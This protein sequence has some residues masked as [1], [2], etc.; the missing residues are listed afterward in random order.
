MSNNGGIVFTQNSVVE[1]MLDIVGYNPNLHLIK[2][3]LLEPACGE[4]AFLLPVVRRLLASM[5]DGADYATL[6]DAIRAYDIEPKHVLR[7][8]EL[9]KTALISSKVSTKDADALI[10]TWIRRGDFL[11]Q[12]NDQKY[13]FIVGNPPYVGMDKLNRTL[14]LRYR[15]LYSTLHDRTDIYVAFIEKSLDI[16]SRAG[17]L[18]FICT[19]RW[20]L[21][22]YGGLLR[23]KITD[24]FKLLNYIDLK[25]T[26]PFESKVSTYPSIFTIAHGRTTRVVTALLDDTSSKSCHS[27]SRALR[28]KAPHKLV[29]K[30][31]ILTTHKKWFQGSNPWLIN[32]PQHIQFLYE[33]EKKYEPIE[34][35]CRVGIGIA[36][37]CDNVYIIGKSMTP[38]IEATRTVPLVMRMDLKD[39]RIQSK[40]NYIINTFEADGTVVNLESYPLLKRY[41]DLHKVAVEKRHVAKKN[42]KHWHRTIDRLHLDLIKKPKL[43]I[44]DIAGCNQV[45]FDPGNFYPHH[46]I[47]HITSDVWDLEVLGG[48]LNS[49]IALF[50]IWSYSMRMRGGYLRFQAQYLRKIRIPNPK[51]ISPKLSQKIKK[52]FRSRDFT[53]IDDLALEAYGL[54]ELPFFK[55]SD[56]RE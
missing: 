9:V 22:R 41:F 54:S 30:Q 20:T 48:L 55:F 3:K 31:P 23:K 38:R 27:I 33:L 13:D 37:G 39:G 36:S 35:T 2:F 12:K 40:G 4:G 53:Q 17:K 15:S 24:D 46:N 45:T 43:L 47:Y 16:L 11:L 42:P 7:S 1:L 28:S 44:P 21:N 6:K 32:T 25:N 29:D 50:F 51:N 8:R 56:Q 34:E 19:D 14:Q 18:C 5:K 49:K 52:A 26:S 10:K